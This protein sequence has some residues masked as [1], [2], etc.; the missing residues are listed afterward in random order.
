MKPMVIESTKLQKFLD[1]I[2]GQNEKEEN[3][4][5]VCVFTLFFIRTRG[6]FLLKILR[7]IQPQQK[8]KVSNFQLK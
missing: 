5:Y 8:N 2:F 3:R 1:A 4:L 7:T 6:S